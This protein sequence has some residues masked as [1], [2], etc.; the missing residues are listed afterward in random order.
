VLAYYDA[1]REYAAKDPPTAACRSTR[2]S[3]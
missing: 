2:A 3:W 1:Q